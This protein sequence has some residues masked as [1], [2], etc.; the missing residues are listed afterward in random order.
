MPAIR[1]QA[2]IRAPACR[3]QRHFSPLT[4][5]TTFKKERLSTPSSIAYHNIYSV[6]S[7]TSSN[8][9]ANPFAVGTTAVSTSV[10]ALLKKPDGEVTRL[11]RGGYNLQAELKWR[12]EFYQECQVRSSVLNQLAHV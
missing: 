7:H 4:V 5:H 12:E 9:A 8:H 6:G 2:T 1:A 10:K 3:A 11:A